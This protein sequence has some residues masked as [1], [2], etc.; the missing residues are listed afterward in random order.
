[1][2]WVSAPCPILYVILSEQSESK[3]PLLVLLAKGWET[4]N[5]KVRTHTVS[6]LVDKPEEQPWSSFRHDAAGVE[7]TVEIES[8][9]T[10]ARRDGSIVP[11]SETPDLG[12]PTV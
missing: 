10:G 11:S 12:H 6:G 7:A 5:P 1:M 4:A 3:D 8:F 2:A 9:W